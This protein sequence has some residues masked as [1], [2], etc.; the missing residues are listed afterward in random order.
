[1]EL[2]SWL[3]F[4]KCFYL[5]LQRT[6]IKT[7]ALTRSNKLSFHSTCIRYATF[8]TTCTLTICHYILH[9]FSRWSEHRPSMR[10]LVSRASNQMM[11][12]VSYRLFSQSQKRITVTPLTRCDEFIHYHAAMRNEV[13]RV[14]LQAHVW[15]AELISWYFLM[16]TFL[17]MVQIL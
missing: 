17:N 12:V 14:Q 5:Y 4:G 15:H 6:N 8:L 1:M 3:S 9:V 2:V 7:H 10:W 13:T 16:I 11:P